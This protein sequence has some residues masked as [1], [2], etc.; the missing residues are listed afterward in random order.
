MHARGDRIAQRYVLG[1]Q[2]AAGGMGIVFAA[3]QLDLDRDVAIKLAHEQVADAPYVR[4]RFRDEAMAL[5]RICHPNVIA[6]LELG[7]TERGPFLVMP[8]LHGVSLASAIAAG[9]WSLARVRSVF[10]Q[11]LAALA[12]AHACGVVHG[13]V[14]SD[15]ILLA[16]DEDGSDRVV[17]IDFG[18]ACIAE[19]RHD[20]DEPHVV[21]GTPEYLAPE[22]IR[23]ERPTPA[24]DLYGAGVVLY[25]L[26][27]G[28][29]PFGGC[30]PADILIRQL[31]EPIEP[32]S[33]RAP[34]RRIPADLERLVMRALDKDPRTRLA[35][36]SAFRMSLRATS[37]IDDE[38]MLAPQP[39]IAL[40]GSTRELTQT[41]APV[42]ASTAI[43][44][45]AGARSTPEGSAESS[46]ESVL[47]R[48]RIAVGEAV[49]SGDVDCIVVA[50]LELASKLI[51]AHRLD[52]AAWELELAVELLGPNGYDSPALWRL[53][54]ALA[55]LWDALG[56]RTRAIDCA[57]R[58]LRS[59]IR[60]ESQTGR[61]RGKALLARL[62]RRATRG[63][64]A[65]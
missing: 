60:S 29:T 63:V 52:A 21:S 27:T 43:A 5:A 14:K 53:L 47:Q 48:A 17:L 24:S 50:Y 19:R 15:N 23:G 31:D 28:T 37:A 22:L 56:D 41:M 25:E 55:A 65:Q 20:R 12:A 49:R 40:S 58:G 10:D 46:D 26:V 30:S 33:R 62:L 11:L 4:R 32:P 6:V 51:D 64:P 45:P 59:A 1:E 36:A 61:E 34:H 57:R 9:T 44:S 38:V 18:L 35:R 8:R 3:R 39:V 7:E 13:D 54:L 42:P 2:L 16:R